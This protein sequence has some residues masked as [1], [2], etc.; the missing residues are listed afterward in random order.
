LRSLQHLHSHRANR[1]WLRGSILQSKNH[2][3]CFAIRKTTMLCLDGASEVCVWVLFINAVGLATMS[4]LAN[5]TRAA[6]DMLNSGSAERFAF[7]QTCSGCLRGSRGLLS[8]RY[9]F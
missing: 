8:S 5:H 3:H 7:R 2:Q 4:A 6:R 1:N 9:L